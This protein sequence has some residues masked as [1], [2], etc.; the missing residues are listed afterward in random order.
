MDADELKRLMDEHGDSQIGVAG[1]LGVHP[2]AISKLLKGKRQ[3]KA[4]E[5]DILRRYYGLK[6]EDKPGRPR[7]LP[8]VGLVSAGQWRE[9]FERI[10]GYMPS[11][12]RSLSKDAFV[13]IIE[14]D[15]MDLVAHEG[16]AIIVDPADRNLIPGKLYVIRNAQ[17][18]ATFKRYF[19]NP[20]R[21]EPCSSNPRH[22]ILYPGQEGFE[23]IGRARKKVTDL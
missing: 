16:E 1:L 13:V 12:D 10:M 20:A 14:G 11:P 7:Q 22:S 4:R 17:G 6:D 23:V 5:A 15:S 18:E 19:E 8:I 2:T 9:G 21:L 3:L